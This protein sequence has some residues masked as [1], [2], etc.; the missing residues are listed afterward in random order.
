MTRPHTPIAEATA[1]A[2]DSVAAA[3]G[4]LAEPSPLEG[5][6]VAVFVALG[7]SMILALA[8]LLRG[9]SLVDRVLALDLLAIFAAGASALAAVSTERNELLIVAV[10]IALLA[11]MGTAAFAMFLERK[12]I[13]G[14]E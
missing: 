13:G 3:A 2:T 9:P 11:F 1:A 14:D 8:R 12:G 6:Y 4:T 7:V 10:L 5:L